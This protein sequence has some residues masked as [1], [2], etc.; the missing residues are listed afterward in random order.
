M[1][2]LTT[3]DRPRFSR[4]M[5]SLSLSLAM[6]MVVSE[7]FAQGTAPAATPGPQSQRPAVTPTPGVQPGPPQ[8]TTGQPA[9]AGPAALPDKSGP[10]PSAGNRQP[11]AGAPCLIAEFRTLALDTHNPTERERV[12]LDWMRRNLPGCSV[13]KL[14]LLG[15]NRASW[16]GTAD[17]ATTMGMIDTAIEAKSQDNPAVLS[18]LFDAV[19]RSFTPTVETIRTEPP[20]PG[21]GVWGVGGMLPPIGIMNVQPGGL[22]NDPPQGP[23]GLNPPIPLRPLR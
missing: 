7:S 21:T 17:S 10:A 3:A 5:A 19:P 20:R 1:S 23:G 18:Q 2:Q 13:E 6:M 9:S 4:S 14:I 8:S 16:L 11:S 12:A 22:Q 15:S